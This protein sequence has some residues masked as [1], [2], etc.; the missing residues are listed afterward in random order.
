[1]GDVQHGGAFEQLHPGFFPIRTGVR[2]GPAKPFRSW[3]AVVIFHDCTWAPEAEQIYASRLVRE[4]AVIRVR[5]SRKEVGRNSYVSGTRYLGL[6][7]AFVSLGL[8]VLWFDPGRHQ[9]GVDGL[10]LLSVLLWVMA[11]RGDAASPR[12]GGGVTVA[13]VV[14]LTVVLVVFAAAWLPFYDNWRWAYTGDS[15]SW[16]TVA[17]GPARHGLPQNI[18]SLRG[19]DG[20]FSF[21]HGLGF[22]ALM[23]VFEPTL[24]WHRVGKLVV[25]CLSLAAIYTYLRLMVGRWFALAVVFCTATNYVWLWFSYVS[26]GHIDSHI[27][28]FLTLFYATLIWRWPERTM[29]WVACGLVG[30]LSLFF[31]QTAWSAVAAVGL[32]LFFFAIWIRR[33]GAFAIYA[34]SF[35]LVAAPV[36]VQLPYLLEMTTRQARA[37]YE[38][39]YLVR[40][41]LAVLRFPYTSG[42][43]N[44]GVFGGFFRW[45]LAE[46]YVVGALLAVIGC[47]PLFRRRL[48][49]PAVAPVLFALL[50]W[51]AVLMTIT[52]NG[53]GQPSTKRAYN[54]IPVQNFLALLPLYL[55]SV[56]VAR[57]VWVRSLVVVATVAVIAVA[58]AGSFEQMA[59]P[60]RGLYGNNSFDGVIELRQRFPERRVLFLT[61]REDYRNALVPEGFF[62]QSYRVLDQLT[63]TDAFDDVTVERACAERR[64]LCTEPHIDRE[65]LAPV[66]AKHQSA[67]QDFPLLNSKD[68]ICYVCSPDA[69]PAL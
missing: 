8:F 20:N 43:Q 26:Y 24:F 5:L 47:V 60:S 28:Y 16:Y 55:A 57:W 13:D 58:A 54:L 69:R 51:D 56:W 3:A 41:F 12:P 39:D 25:S 14:P 44:I 45:P 50:L 36:L 67:L 40:I 61:S 23:F 62:H 48:R 68:L 19:V 10:W 32:V 63:L 21:L 4:I 66:L 11:V 27:F 35:L 53:Y 22:N 59:H 7:A 1:M 9:W 65:R 33:L 6:T 31:T 52:N 15:I 37:I 64:I 18:L 30:G 42:Y 34:T 38:W 49:I 29:Y 17:A 46:L 2:R